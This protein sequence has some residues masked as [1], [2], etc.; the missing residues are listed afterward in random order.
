MNNNDDST[1][2]N[3]PMDREPRSAQ[4]AGPDGGRPSDALTELTRGTS[5]SP[6]PK[7][8]ARGN[9]IDWVRPTDLGPRVGAAIV[10]RG[11]DVHRDVHSWARARLRDAAT[12]SERKRRLPPPSAFGNN[13]PPPPGRDAIGL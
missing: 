4:K 11:A 2:S 6:H 7:G 8:Q 5:L 12:P 1:G 10:N 3:D 9:G 13:G